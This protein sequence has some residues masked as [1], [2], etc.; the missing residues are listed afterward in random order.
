[1]QASALVTVVSR[2]VTGAMIIVT[3]AFEFASLPLVFFV[4]GMSLAAPNLPRIMK[5]VG[6]FATFSPLAVMGI[7]ALSWI[8]LE[9]HRNLYLA[10]ALLLVAGWLTFFVSIEKT[11]VMGLISSYASWHVALFDSTLRLFGY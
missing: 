10:A 9:R 5:F 8:W 7:L 4:I 11:S 1:M 6:F 3:I 2:Y